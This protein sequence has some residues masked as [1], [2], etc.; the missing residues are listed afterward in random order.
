MCCVRGFRNGEGAREMLGGES[1]LQWF[2][3][4]AP[5]PPHMLK[6]RSPC[7][8]IQGARPVGEIA[9]SLLQMAGPHP[10]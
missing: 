2:E 9:T 1:R 6:S 8:G 3:H 4:A 10:L 5:A 7:N